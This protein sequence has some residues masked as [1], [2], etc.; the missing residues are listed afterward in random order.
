MDKEEKGEYM[1]LLFFLKSK[2]DVTYIDESNTARQALETMKHHGF[3]AVPVVSDD[4]RYVGTI[5][6]GDLLWE[7]LKHDPFEYKMSEHIYVKDMI[8]QQLN[9]AARVDTSMADLLLMAT[10]QNFI[11]I[12]DDRKLFIGIVTR[13]D[14][15]QYYYRLHYVDNNPKEFAEEYQ[16]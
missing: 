9:P 16:K 11:P 8:R 14:I 4:G 12:I 15:L 7:I 3:T 5:T 13:K 10:K 1:N 6:E 2:S